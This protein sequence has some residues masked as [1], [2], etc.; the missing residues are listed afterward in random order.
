M[1]LCLQVRHISLVMGAF[2]ICFNL[3]LFFFIL[4]SSVPS[5][6]LFPFFFF[7]FLTF[8]SFLLPFQDN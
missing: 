3:S 8:S 7:F 1:G 5:Y 4:P 6:T 2:S